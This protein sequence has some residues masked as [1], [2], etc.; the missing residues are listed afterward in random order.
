MNDFMEFLKIRKMYSEILPEWDLE[1]KK[2]GDMRQDPY[3]Y[4]W[5]FTPIEK[6]VFNDIRC[7]GLPFY[8][9]IPVLNFFIDFGCPFLKIGIECDG[10]E[11]HDVEK[12]FLRDRKLEDQG[13]TIFR[14]EGHEC[15]RYINP[16]ENNA[17]IDDDLVEKFFFET[18]EGVLTAIKNNY[19]EAKKYKYSDLCARTLSM[20][21]STKDNVIRSRA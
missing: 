17:D 10:K 18:S 13:W 14:I 5:K 3:F 21:R 12:D 16:W 2:T 1:Y 15:A 9:Q 4:D 6:H 8:P 7:L 20:H 19:F 11:W